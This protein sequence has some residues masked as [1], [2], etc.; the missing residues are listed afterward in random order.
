[1]LALTTQET[2]GKPINDVQKDNSARTKLEHS[3]SLLDKDE[4]HTYF[5]QEYDA[6][7]GVIKFE[8]SLSDYT[9]EVKILYL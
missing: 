3:L 4:F 2:F 8:D 6:Y 7:W 1:M 5:Q 9:T